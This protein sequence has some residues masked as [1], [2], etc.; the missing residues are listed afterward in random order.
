MKKKKKIKKSS[1]KSGI[2]P[3]VL[4]EYKNKPVNRPEGYNPTGVSFR[5]YMA[6][7]GLSAFPRKYDI[8]APRFT[9]G[10]SPGSGKRA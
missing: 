4:A 6:G 1:I 9:Q 5:D 10:G 8:P 3:R 2:D 7:K